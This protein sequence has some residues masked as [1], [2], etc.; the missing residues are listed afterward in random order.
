MRG[1]ASQPEKSSSRKARRGI[2]SQQAP[3]RGMDDMDRGSPDPFADRE[4]LE[5]KVLRVLE[6]EVADVEDCSE[7][8]ELHL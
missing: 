5:S 6:D 4:L 2:V 7:P 3:T 1:D 8:V